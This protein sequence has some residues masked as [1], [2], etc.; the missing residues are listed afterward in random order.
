MINEF[1]H[2]TCNRFSSVIKLK[3]HF[4]FTLVN[5]IWVYAVLSK[6]CFWNKTCRLLSIIDGQ[7]ESSLVR[8]YAEFKTP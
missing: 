6:L 1:L 3:N 5:N 4:Q 7:I 8:L 2:W